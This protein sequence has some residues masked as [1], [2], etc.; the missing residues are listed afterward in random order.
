MDGGFRLNRGIPF[1]PAA[2]QQARL[3]TA[4]ASV[5][6]DQVDRSLFVPHFNALFYLRSHLRAE[7]RHLIVKGG[8]DGNRS[9]REL[10]KHGSLELTRT[11]LESLLVR[12]QDEIVAPLDLHRRTFVRNDTYL[13]QTRLR[14]DA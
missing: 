12:P 4:V 13:V 14:T 10:R 7:S 2:S 1:H 8:L 11:N 9:R 3:D 6:D 5:L